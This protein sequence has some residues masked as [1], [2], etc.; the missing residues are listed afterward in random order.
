ML[1]FPLPYQNEL[2][3]S[4]VARAGIRLALSS[5]KQLLDEIFQNRKV[6]A[7]VDLPCHLNAIIN[8]FPANQV[9]LEDIA[10]QHTLF[11]IYAPFVPENRRQQCLQ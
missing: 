11:P 8:Q 1:N 5:P 9:S 7:T 10:Y 6:I 2:I 4:T 3:Y